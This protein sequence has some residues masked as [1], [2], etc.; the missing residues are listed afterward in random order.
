MNTREGLTSGPLPP[1]GASMR[2]LAVA[3]KRWLAGGP[4]APASAAAQA[5]EAAW[6]AALFHP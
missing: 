5:L 3:L 6:R 2:A 1:I 4:P